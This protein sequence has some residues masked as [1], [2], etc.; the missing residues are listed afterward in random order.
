LTQQ[1]E[2]GGPAVLQTELAGLGEAVAG[3]GATA[4]VRGEDVPSVTGDDDPACVG[5]RLR[6]EPLRTFRAPL[7]C[8]RYD[9][10]A[11]LP[12]A[13]LKASTTTRSPLP[14]KAKLNGLRPCD[15][16]RRGSAE[17]R[18]FGFTSKTSMAFLGDNVTL[19]VF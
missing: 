14:R 1:A 9:D 15:G 13:A 3:D 6:I 2:R 4:E 17:V 7:S 19:V 18:P 16:A 11:D 8:T 5:C 12:S 10:T